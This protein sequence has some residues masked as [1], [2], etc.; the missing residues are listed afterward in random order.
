MVV[1]VVVVVLMYVY[2]FDEVFAV[3]VMITIIE[4]DDNIDGAAVVDNPD[5]VVL[6]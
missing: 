5:D 2:N 6:K 3:M 1:P 4:G